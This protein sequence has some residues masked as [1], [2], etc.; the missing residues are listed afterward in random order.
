MM[1]FNIYSSTY[2][3]RM[4]YILFFALGADVEF[5]VFQFKV[6]FEFHLD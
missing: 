4:K 6:T 5:F 1:T 2:V 3:F